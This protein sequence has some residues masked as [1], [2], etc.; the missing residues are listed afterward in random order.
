VS[1][2]AVDLAWTDNASNESGFTVERSPDGVTGWS[3]VSSSVAAGATSYRDSGLTA[4]TSY[5]YRV[6]ATNAAG[7]SAYSNVASVT[8]PAQSAVVFAESFAGADGSA[9]VSGRWTGDTQTTASLDVLGGA[10]RMGFQNVSGARAQAKATM[11]ATADTETLMSF[12]FPSTAPRGYFYLF[13]RGSG[14]WVSG[15][16]GT[17]YF[18]QF[19]NDDSSVQLWKSSAGTTTQLAS[20]ANAAA[21]TTTKQW[22]RFRVEGSTLKAKVWTDGAAEPAAW[23][24]SASDSTVTA[25]G[26]LQVKWSRSSSAT[27]AR[28]V[29]LDDIEVASLGG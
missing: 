29:L 3:V 18:L 20:V 27:A 19:G 17:S 8:T 28:D 5:S 25:A 7:G 12:R 1:A 9:W 21:V 2:S 15:Y 22:V 13:A 10:G 6:K 23:E 4:S 16:P 24:V 11:T 14:N 26:V